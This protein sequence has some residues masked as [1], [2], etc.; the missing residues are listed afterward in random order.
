MPELAYP[1][2]PPLVDTESSS[3][4]RVILRC[5]HAARPVVEGKEARTSKTAWS[6]GTNDVIA[7]HLVDGLGQPHCGTEKELLHGI[8]IGAARL[9]VI[10]RF[11]FS[12]VPSG[13]D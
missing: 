10:L 11:R 5:C 3:R 9:H 4:I 2:E 7:E 8:V 13:H 12:N 6:R 1:Q